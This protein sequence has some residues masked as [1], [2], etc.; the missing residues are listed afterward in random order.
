MPAGIY[1]R[2]CR[3]VK[4]RLWSKIDKNTCLGDVCGCQKG[5]G[6]CWP[7]MGA[8]DQNGYGR[9]RVNGKTVGANH[10]VFELT[11]HPL[12]PKIGACHHCDNQPCCRP[13]H[14]FAGTQGDNM[15]DCSRKY[16]CSGHKLT[17]DEV[18]YAIK[19]HGHMSSRMIGQQLNVSHEAIL[20]I[21][22]KNNLPT[23]ALDY[24]PKGEEHGRSK[25]TGNE[26]LIIRALRRIAPS[27]LISSIFGIHK[28]HVLRL[29]SGN[30]WQHVGA[31]IIEFEG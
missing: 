16:R 23:I 15:R 9:I 2:K 31:P 10:L 30:L 21:W 13:E 7:F 19:A 18:E 26:V 17:P 4:E 3:P 12:P 27:S 24:H 5:I 6:H 29:W 14:L 20:H 25:L 11:Y 1:P 22:R 28:D 8:R